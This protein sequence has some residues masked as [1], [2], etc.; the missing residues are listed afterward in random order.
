MPVA[1]TVLVANIVIVMAVST[2]ARSCAYS[3]PN[4]FSRSNGHSVSYSQRQNMVGAAA[5]FPPTAEG[6]R[7]HRVTGTPQGTR[8]R[9]SSDLLAKF[10]PSTG[11][12]SPRQPG[13]IVGIARSGF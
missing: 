2:V 11:G 9:S 10:C 7:S 5:T 1:V 4:S 3:F 13:Q 6:G 12:P 8:S